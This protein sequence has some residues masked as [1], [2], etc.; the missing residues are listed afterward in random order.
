MEHAATL[1]LEDFEDPDLQDKLDR[2]RRQTMGRMNLMSQLFGQVQDAITVVSFAAGLLVYAPW[3]IVLLAVALIPGVR[4]RG[5]LQRARLLAQLPVDAGTPPARIPAPDGRERRDREGGEDLQPPPLLHRALPRACRTSSSSPTAASR[6]GARCGAR[7]WPRSARSA[8]TSPTPT[9]PGARCKGDFSIGDLTFLAG[10]FRRLRQ[11][12]EGLLVG[13]SQVAGQALY[14]D[15]LYL[16]LRD[17]AGDPFASPTPL[18]VPQPDRARLRVR[19]RRLPLSRCR[20]LGAARPGL[21][22]ARRRSAGAGRRERRRQDHAGETAGA[23][24][25]PGRR[26]HPARRP[27][28]ARLRPR[29]PAREHR[30]DLPGLRAL[31]PHRRRE[32]RRRPDRRDGRPRRAS[33][34]RRGARS[35][36]R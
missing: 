11:L 31:P 32:H 3:L 35:P 5:A 10:S 21:R 26:P 8:T 13:F 12:L 2:A 14:L 23:P 4:R 9:S 17:R 19:E 7:C 29:R 24:V 16:V 20:A 34:R 27:R 28:P 30:R 18:P 15:D 22:T 33:T 6:A 36:T 1:D 25:R